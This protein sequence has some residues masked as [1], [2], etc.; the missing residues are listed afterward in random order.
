ML[1]YINLLN[2]PAGKPSLLSRKKD[3][4]QEGQWTGWVTQQVKTEPSLGLTAGCP[5]AAQCASLLLTPPSPILP[6]EG[7]GQ[8]GD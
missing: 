1:V 4:T 3:K 5:V 6:P 8:Q 2:D 7:M